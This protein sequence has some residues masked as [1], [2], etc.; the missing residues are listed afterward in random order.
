[1]SNIAYVINFDAWKELYREYFE[2]FN[3]N[4]G[5]LTYNADKLNSINI[6][7]QLPPKRLIKVLEYE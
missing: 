7:Y 4:N 2:A 6:F 1:M 5:I 3:W